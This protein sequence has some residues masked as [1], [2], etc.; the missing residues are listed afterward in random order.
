[1][2]QVI[3]EKPT[4]PLAATRPRTKKTSAPNS[5]GPIIGNSSR[6]SL[7]LTKQTCLSD[8]QQDD[9]VFKHPER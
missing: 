1:M 8:I 9:P 3:V 7:I 5:F 4:L 6:Q 2:S